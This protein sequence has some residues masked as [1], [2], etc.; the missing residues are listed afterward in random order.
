MRI[1]QVNR[2]NYIT[3]L[4]FF[5]VKTRHCITKQIGRV[6]P[7]CNSFDTSLARF[8]AGGPESKRPKSHPYLE[9]PLALPRVYNVFH[10]S[11]LWKYIPDSFHVIEHDPVQLQ[12]LSYEEQLVQILDQREKQLRRTTV[13]LVK[14]SRPTMRCQKIHGS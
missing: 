11:Q 6:G 8:N 12:D 7:S 5:K 4:N 2:L 1:V 10:V 13:P 9:L 3:K 14:S